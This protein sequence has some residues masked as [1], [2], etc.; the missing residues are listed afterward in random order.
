LSPEFQLIA[1]AALLWLYDST[2]LLYA[3][4]VILTCGRRQV[5]RVSTAARGLIIAGRQVCFLN[6]FGFC[7][8]AV[9]LRWNIFSAQEAS[10]ADTAW[11]VELQQLTLAA[12]WAVTAGLGLF[13]LLPLGL[14]TSLG[15]AAILPAVIL[16]YGSIGVALLL[17]RRKCRQL[18]VLSRLKFAGLVF[19]CVACPP[20]GI[21][22]V[23]RAGL[24]SRI[25][26]SLTTAAPR[27]LAP[28]QLA[29]LATHC[30]AILEEELQRLEDSSPLR[31]VIVQK[32][33][34]F[35]RWIERT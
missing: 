9:R 28:P 6:P 14:F 16:V 12:P 15:A 34:G 8:P 20:L 24:M 21:G 23:R 3:D 32:R 26:E 35:Q 7:R 17:I 29:A 4:E 1:L 25:E 13:V 2:A 33:S 11:V 31:H 30:I 10:G 5:W 19:E 22:V 27:L 18:P